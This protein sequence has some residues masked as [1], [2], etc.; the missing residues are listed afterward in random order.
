MEDKLCKFVT[1]LANQR[2]KHT[3]IK[4]YLLATCHMQISAGQSDPFS[5]GLWPKLHYVSG[6]INDSPN[7]SGHCHCEPSCLQIQL[8]QSK[9]DPFRRRIDIYVG[10][11]DNSFCPVV[12]MPSYLMTRG[13]TPGLLFQFSNGKLLTRPHL[14]HHLCQ[15][16]KG[17]RT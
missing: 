10:R 13:F 12:A 6:G 8:K 5:T 17:A 3:S 14:V 2:V 7:P 15:T 9:T 1:L 16:L 11:T 4:C